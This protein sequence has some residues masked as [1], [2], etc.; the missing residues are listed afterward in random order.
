MKKIFFLLIFTAV[1]FLPSSFSYTLE[2]EKNSFSSIFKMDSSDSAWVE[3]EFSKLTLREKCAQMIF[4]NVWSRGIDTASSYYKEVLELV[5]KHKIGGIIYS[6][7]KIEEQVKLTNT[8]QSLSQVPLMISA[9]YERGLGMRLSDAVEFPYNMAFAAAGDTRLSYYAG[10]ATAIEARAIG[11]HQNYAPIVDVNHDYR[12]PIINIR[13]YSEDPL[14]IAYHSAAYIRGLHEGN[15]IS[16]VKHF[17]GHGATDLDSHKELPV[18]NSTKEEFEKSDLVPFRLAIKS[19]VK[20]VMIG[21]LQVPAYE[22]TEGMPATFSE[23][24]V[25][26]LLRKKM[27]FDGLV[28]TDA[29]NM[30]A[31]VDNFSTYEAMKLAVNA[32][33]DII[34]YPPDVEEAINAL[35]SAVTNNDIDIELINSSVKKIL[36]AKRWLGLDKEKFIDTTKVKKEVIDNINHK[37]LAAEVAEKSITLVKDEQNLI[38]INPADYYKTSC[39]FLTDRTIPYKPEDKIILDEYLKENFNYVKTHKLVLTNGE[40]DFKNAFE[41]ARNSNLILLPVFL[42]IKSFEGNILLD[43]TY[44]EFISKILKLNKPTILISLGNPYILSDIPDAPAY[45]CSYGRVAV[46][47]KAVVDAMLGRINISGRLPVSI[48]NTKY[49]Y[50]SGLQKKSSGLYFPKEKADS[51]YNFAVVDS[52]MSK[53]IADSVFPGSV[54]LIAQRGKVIY[55][56][57]FGKYTYENTAVEI[58]EESM[59]DIA[60]LTKVLGTTSA[61]MFLYDEGK[62]K[63]DEYVKTYLPEFAANGKEKVTV[64]NILLHNSGLPAFKPFYKYLSKAEDVVADIMNTKLNSAPGEKYVYSDLGIIT[65]QKIIEK[66]SGKTLDEY[67]KEKLFVPLKLEHI[68]FNP[69]VEYQYYCVPTE[70][71]KEWRHSLIKGKVHDE[72]SYLLNGIAGHAG[73]FSTAADAAVIM[74]VLM[75]NGSYG[76]KQFFKSATVEEWTKVQNEKSTRGLGWDTKSEENSSAGT[77]FSQNSFGHTGFTGTSIWADKERDLFVILFTNRVYP[78]RDNKKIIKFRPK[79]HDAI[80][81]AVDYF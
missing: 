12:N 40:I 9:D 75:N 44:V 41:D 1:I 26:D 23:K 34:I 71:D 19:G 51:N 63:L 53:G 46:S 2:N 54:L 42:N 35:D 58:S 20:S 79:L 31:V 24:I 5:T 48:P 72:T 57:P 25:N 61:A 36:A 27:G 7:G 6:I 4:A 64:R 32:G 43:T 78:T 29:M 3:A 50:K 69:P 73:L 21:H 22:D 39:I 55:R 81:D 14:E 37:R 28:V 60:S 62:I 17:P 10:K 76:G 67:L 11:V 30:L 49:I 77:K 66:I 52:L 47:Q 59:F 16:S 33:N 74:Q 80:I 45:I 56:K 15:M 18:I 8:L 38:P 65:L 68:M 13:S 70:F